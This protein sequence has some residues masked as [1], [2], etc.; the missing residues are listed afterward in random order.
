MIPVNKAASRWH[1]PGHYIPY[2]KR[3]STFRI[4]TH[5][6]VAADANRID[7]FETKRPADIVDSHVR[8]KAR[9]R[10]IPPGSA[11]NDDSRSTEARSRDAA[12]VEPPSTRTHVIRRAPSS[13][14]T[15][16][17]SRPSSVEGTE[18]TWMPDPASAST[19]SRAARSDV[20]R[21]TGPSPTDMAS[22]DPGSIPPD[23]LT[24]A[25]TGFLRARTITGRRS[26]SSWE[27]VLPPTIT[28]SLSARRRCTSRLAGSPVIHRDRPC[29]SAVL[30]SSVHAILRVTNGSPVVIHLKKPRLSSRQ[31]DSSSPTST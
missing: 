12:S 13:R 29:L 20:K 19:R 6:D 31:A 26:G 28:Q 1:I 15:A 3:P 21:N 11:R 30:P 14:R 5:A 2:L 27:A 4:K 24:T 23:P 17:R 25:R 16:G 9:G 10:R 18:M 7:Q 22:L 8:A